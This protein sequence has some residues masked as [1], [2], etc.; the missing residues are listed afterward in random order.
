MDRMLSQVCSDT[1]RR[2]TVAT[3]S[4]ETT[5]TMEDLSS[6][7]TTVYSLT[8]PNRGDLN[9]F[10][11][12]NSSGDPVETELMYSTNAFLP[13]RLLVDRRCRNAAYIGFDDG[14]P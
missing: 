2:F 8:R 1:T 12:H 13:S 14:F 11:W 3:G 6:Q 7:E 5:V 10:T 9:C 4:E